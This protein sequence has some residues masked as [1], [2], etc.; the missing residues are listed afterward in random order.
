MGLAAGWLLPL[1]TYDAVSDPLS[2]WK[3]IP[4]SISHLVYTAP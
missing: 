3:K 1:G 4:L 2:A